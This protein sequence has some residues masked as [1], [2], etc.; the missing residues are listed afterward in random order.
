MTLYEISDTM[1]YILNAIDTDDE[2]YDDDILIEAWESATE[3]LKDK[4]DTWCKIIKAMQADEN[5]LTE[6]IHRL[7]ARRK[8]IRNNQ[9]R[10]KSTLCKELRMM[11][12]DKLKTAFFTIHSLKDNSKV[13]YD[14][15]LIGDEFRIK[16]TAT[17]IDEKA[18][19][20]A[21]ASGEQIAGAKLYSSL[22]IR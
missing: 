17:K 11:E 7:E 1:K 16:Y 10:M 5:K 22:T 15:A 9:I 21:L 3:D 14:S 2:Q 8:S 6:E 19:K 13:V 20:E 18:V 12:V 4:A